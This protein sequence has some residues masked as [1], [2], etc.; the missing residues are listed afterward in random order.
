MKKL[1]IIALFFVAGC[2]T[3]PVNI[4]NQNPFIGTWQCYGH[5]DD[6]I[7]P[8]DTITITTDSI[9]GFRYFL[10]GDTIIETGYDTVLVNT[11]Y[12]SNDT[13]YFSTVPPMVTAT[14]HGTY[15]TIRLCYVMKKI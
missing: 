2:L 7:H 4:Q 12:H 15:D 13:F 1:V 8:S 11:Y 3:N 6:L 5:P 10:R 9:W 14:T